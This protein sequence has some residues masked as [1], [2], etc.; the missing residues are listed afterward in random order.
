MSSNFDSLSNVAKIREA[1]LSKE[2]KIFV[3]IIHKTFFQPGSG[4]KEDAL[5]R[6]LG[7]AG[8]RRIARRVLSML[9]EEGI[10]KEYPGRQGPVFIPARKHT[11]RMGQIV[12][13]LKYSNDP[14]WMRL[15][16]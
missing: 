10:L 8:D 16:T 6:G 4:R 7:A 1:K 14:L 3:T 5:M 2:Q 12:S 15:E 11:R 9:L 13:Q